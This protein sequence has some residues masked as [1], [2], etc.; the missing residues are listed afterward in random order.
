VN[1][2]LKRSG[3]LSVVLAGA[4][5][6]SS[7]WIEAL[8]ACELPLSTIQNTVRADAYGS[9]VITGSTRRP[10]GLT[11][12]FGATRSK[13][14]ACRVPPKRRGRSARAARRRHAARGAL[15]VR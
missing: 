14:L 10:D 11:P 5:P 2:H 13:G 3:D 1:V 8:P 6:P 12:V 15:V 4:Q 9:L 7:R